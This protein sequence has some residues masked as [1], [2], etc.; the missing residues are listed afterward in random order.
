M[1]KI[2]LFDFGS[3]F[4]NNVRNILDN[5][6]VIYDFVKHDYAFKNDKDVVGIILTGSKDAVYDNGRRCDSRY[7]NL[8]VPIF[9]ICYGHQLCND[10]FNGKVQKAEVSEMNKKVLL[11]IDVD[12]PIFKDIEKDNF[13]AM[14]HYD[15]VVKLGDGFINLAHTND[16]KIAAAYNKDKNIYTVQFHPEDESMSQYCDKYFTN[17]FDICGVKYK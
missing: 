15:E 6:E 2:L 5:H 17:F 12:N 3:K 8:G 14:H 4:T 13:V 9:G 16:C 1:K 10:E 7:F 11:H